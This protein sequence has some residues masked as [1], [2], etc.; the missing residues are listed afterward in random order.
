MF[1]QSRIVSSESHNIRTSSGPSAKRTLRWIGLSR[2]FKVILI[3]VSRNPE[4]VVVIMYNNVDIIFETYD[5]TAS[6]KTANSSI[7]T[8]PLQ[9]DDSNPR[10]AFEYLEMIYI[11]L[12]NLQNPPPARRKFPQVLGATCLHRSIPL[13]SGPW[14]NDIY[15]VSQKKACDAIYLSII[16]ILIAR[17]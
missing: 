9:F 8:T 11:D 2:S 14:H 10:N 1:I 6:R 5:D 7:F 4:R 3:G 17:L 13:C 15:T 16:R 12:G